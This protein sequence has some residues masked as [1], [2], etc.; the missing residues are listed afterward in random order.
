[1][2]ENIQDFIVK[3]LLED[4]E[5]F[6]NVI[7]NI[8]TDHFD[9]GRSDII[10]MVK[11]YFKT[12]DNIPTYDVLKNTLRKNKDT[13]NRKKLEMIVNHLKKSKS[14]EMSDAKW[15][16]DETKVFVRN[17]SVESLL[18]TGA[19]YVENNDKSGITIE[20][21]HRS[22]QDIVGMTW[23]ENLGIEFADTL[24]FDEVYD[25]LETITKRVPTGIRS[26][27]DEIGGGIEI[28]TSSLC[29]MC[30][31]AGAGKSMFLQNIAVNA[32]KSGHNVVY[33]S[34]ELVETQLRKRMD[35]TF[36]GIDIT[37]LIKSREVLKEKITKMYE[38]GDIGR[39]FIKEYPTGTCTI[40]DIE[41]YI[42]K[43][44]LQK[45]FV[46]DMIIVD[47]LGIMK[48]LDLGG[49][50]NSYEKTK[51][52]CEELRGYSGKIKVPIISASQLNRGG[53]AQ[54]SVGLDN[55]ADSMGIAHTADLVLALTTTDQLKED[56]KLRFEVLKSRL[57]RTGGVGYFQ[58]DWDT[59]TIRNE[60]EDT[61]QDEQL[62][63]ML[64]RKKEKKAKGS[65]IK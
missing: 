10:D 16:L 51:R 54:E 31:S 46:P 27:D 50:S 20:G 44:K 43:L 3:G 30:G 21:I 45:D 34:F 55:I 47:Y 7:G 41:N 4:R 29:V 24:Q 5:Y 18:F 1:L 28:N 52:V 64:N 9:D 6:R 25:Q 12:Y 42:S 17:K 8:T 36:S 22:M 15:L 48:P 37:K 2:L 49:Q 23:D 56:N 11:D 40:L 53:V 26:L 59:L 62:K 14:L 19:E 65:G 58:I 63:E 57:S 13:L 35:S 60:D 61:A 39:M 38:T 32:I 33:L